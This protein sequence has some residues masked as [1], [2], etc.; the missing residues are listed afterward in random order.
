MR[1][2]QIEGESE[3]KLENRMNVTLHGSTV[4]RL[5]YQRRK[6]RPKHK[7]SRAGIP[8]E[9]RNGDTPLGYSGRT[10]LRR[11]QCD[12]PDHLLGNGMINTYP[13]KCET[14]TGHPL[15]CNVP[16]NKSRGNKYA[17]IGCPV[18]DSV[19]VNKHATVEEGCFLGVVRAEII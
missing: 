18:L 10:A 19:A 7:T 12:A 6:R 15:L 4:E 13:L 14:T 3:R 11:E 17:T 8:E 1:E 2:R 5:E 9:R 16:I